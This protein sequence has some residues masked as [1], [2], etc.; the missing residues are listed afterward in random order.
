MHTVKRC[1]KCRSY[2]ADDKPLRLSP[3]LVECLIRAHKRGGEVWDVSDW[4][5]G[6]RLKELGLA[7]NRI[8]MTAAQIEVAVERQCNLANVAIGEFRG[9]A[10][11]RAQKA[12]Q[13]AASITYNTRKELL[14]LTKLGAA[15]A[16]WYAEKLQSLTIF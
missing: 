14:M 13:D 6:V 16:R 8:K 7:E 4:S 5:D 2:I 1:R 12:L 3:T 10:V 11:E 9:G 15:V